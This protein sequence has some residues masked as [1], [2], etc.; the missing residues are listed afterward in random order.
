MTEF[1]NIYPKDDMPSISDSL[2]GLITENVDSKFL[3]MALV[4]LGRICAV[5]AQEGERIVP[6]FGQILSE[7]RTGAIQNA[8]LLAISDLCVTKT[9]LVDK[10]LDVLASTLDGDLKPLVQNSLLL[11]TSLLKKDFVKMRSSILSRM[12]ILAADDKQ[13]AEIRKVSLCH[14]RVVHDSRRN[15]SLLMSANWRNHIKG[16]CYLLPSRCDIAKSTRFILRSLHSN[17]DSLY[18]CSSNRKSRS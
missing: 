7:G 11:L 6:L 5:N 3:E 18:W 1:Y 16:T 14:S 10:F 12:L 2:V 17:H 4:G 15:D 13:D 9:Q 8:A